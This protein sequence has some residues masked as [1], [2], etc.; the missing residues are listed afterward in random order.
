MIATIRTTTGRENIVI[1]SITSKVKGHAIPIKSVFHPEDLRGYIFIEGEVNDIEAGIKG[2]PHVRGLINKDVPM[3]QLERFLIV[4][5]QEIKLEVGD[6]VEIIGGP[7]KG[8]K[9]KITRVDETKNEI[10]VEFLEAAIPIPVTISVNT[11]RMH[12]KKR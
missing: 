5:K 12:E 2:I 6:V 3:E 10:T 11:V 1:E 7:F 8:E 9:G 4:A